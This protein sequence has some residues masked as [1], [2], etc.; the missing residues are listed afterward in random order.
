MPI[1]RTMKN[2]KPAYQYG[3]TGAKYVYTPG[4]AASRKAAKRRPLSRHW[5]FNLELESLHIFNLGSVRM[6]RKAAAKSAKKLPRRSRH[7]LKQQADRE[8]GCC[9]GAG[10]G[11]LLELSAKASVAQL[12]EPL[13]CNQR[14]AGSSPAAGFLIKGIP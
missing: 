11:C 6:A 3:P 10:D 5:Q 13:T 8:E 4:N 7:P 1:Q 2:G 9:E 14:V 12:A